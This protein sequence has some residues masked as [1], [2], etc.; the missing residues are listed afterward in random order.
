[1]KRPWARSAFMGG[2]LFLRL[3]ASAS[4]ADPPASPLAP[5]EERATF[6]FADP[7]LIADLIASEPDI[8]APV[9]MAWDGNGRLFVAEMTDYPVGPVSGRIRLLENPDATGRYR[10]SKVFADK[11]AFP[12]GVMPWKNGVL[13]TAAP[14][15]W[16]LADTNGDGVADVR[17]KILTGFVEG[18]QQLRVNGLFWG[19]DNWIYGANGRSGGEVKW[20]N[21]AS[22][23]ISIRNRD[24]RFRPDL[25]TFEAIAGH[26]Q[27]GMGQDD[28]GNRFP[29]F[30]N[31]P[32]RHVV[33]EQFYLDRQPLLA[34]VDNVPNIS[35]TNDDRRVF[36]LAP[37]LLMIPQP[38]GYFTSACGPSILRGN[39]LGKNYNGDAFICEPVQNVITRRKLIPEGM[40]FLA[41][42]PDREKEFLAATDPWFHGVFTTTGPD[43]CLYV[44]DFYRKYVEHPHWVADKFKTT[45]PWREGESH[46]RIWRIRDLRLNIKNAAPRLEGMKPR[47]LVKQLSAETGWWRDT[48][49]RLLVE[50]QDKSIVRELEKMARDGK[51]APSRLHAL[52]TLNG[53]N[54][55]TA[56]MVAKSLTDPAPEIKTHAVRLAEKWLREI[57]AGNDGKVAGKIWGQ[58]TLLVGDE[59]SSASVQFQI[60]CTLGEVAS[61]FEPSRQL[62]RLANRSSLSFWEIQAVLSSAGRHAWPIL[63]ELTAVDEAH[64]E[65]L[66]LG[67]QLARA[68][69]LQNSPNDSADFLKSLGASSP[70]RSLC[71]VAGLVE[72]TDG[73][74]RRRLLQDPGVL[75]LL[76]LAASAL[77]SDNSIPTKIAAVRVVSGLQPLTSRPRLLDLLV[78]GEAESLQLAAARA[79]MEWNDPETAAVAFQNW[80]H[81]SKAVRK[82]IVAMSPRFSRWSEALVGQV[83]SQQISAVEVDAVTRQALSRSGGAPFRS[84]VEDL[85][86]SPRD[87]E[88]IVKQFGPAADMPANP[89]KGALTFVRICGVCHSIQGV[90]AKV[91]PDLSGIVTHS[92]ETLLVDLFDPS[93]QV[94]PDFISYTVIKKGGET[95][96]GV[97]VAETPGHV[98]LRNANIPDVSIPRQAIQEIKAEGKSL[99]PDGLEQGLTVQDV[100]DLLEFLHHPDKSLFPTEAK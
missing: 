2:A 60:A 39:G 16:F 57:P 85:F 22:A 24:F 23:K 45:T 71:L 6:H 47:E 36:G 76:S 11:L 19:I 63:R 53:L 5:E 61:F 31:L 72:G 30:N 8:T 90:G 52:Q 56:E 38:V 62:T 33:M 21:D 92:K 79:L 49:Q 86:A 35:P 73:P 65:R 9:A 1:M 26:S 27:F 69:A 97:I 88:A 51:T 54:S 77:H 42:R 37:P 48:A 58:L 93:R 50:K 67:A 25:K 55:L 41:T 40:T 15:I 4:A 3:G 87:R 68:I 7:N 84:R 95:A 59:T 99:M 78:A 46:G 75:P 14:D 89:R 83:E 94:L 70:S 12:N 80:N 34:A 44:V 98:T 64:P 43:G 17:E 10:S 13:V 81:L 91:G 100:A 66:Q 96:T 74:G 82:Q 20:A 32:M 29:V 28:W 18:N